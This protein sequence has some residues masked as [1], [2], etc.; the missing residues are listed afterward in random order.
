MYHW[1]FMIVTSFNLIIKKKQYNIFMDAWTLSNAKILKQRNM[2][3][4]LFMSW[5]SMQRVIT[6]IQMNRISNS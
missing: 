6:P 3:F 1:V 5:K 2:K 4:V